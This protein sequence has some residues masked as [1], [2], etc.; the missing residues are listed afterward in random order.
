MVPGHGGRLRRKGMGLAVSVFVG[1]FLWM[2]FMFASGSP[3]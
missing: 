2:F 3:V 1:V